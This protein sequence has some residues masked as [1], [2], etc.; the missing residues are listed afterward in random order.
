MLLIQ[1]H[2][3]I[4]LL[5]MP[6]HRAEGA[7]ASAILMQSLRCAEPNMLRKGVWMRFTS[8]LPV[9]ILCC[10]VLMQIDD[11]PVSVGPDSQAHTHKAPARQVC[12]YEA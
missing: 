9:F 4:F 12:H 11:L 2:A 7:L 3:A 1:S 5:Y 10:C 8:V 6:E